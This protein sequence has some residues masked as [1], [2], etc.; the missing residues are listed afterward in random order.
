MVINFKVAGKHHILTFTGI[1]KLASTFC[2]KCIFQVFR[3]FKTSCELYLYRT[4]GNFTKSLSRFWKIQNIENHL[5]VSYI[6]SQKAYCGHGACILIL[7][8]VWTMQLNPSTSQL[9]VSCRRNKRSEFNLM[10]HSAPQLPI[11]NNFA[12]M[13]LQI[14]TSSPIL[15]PLENFSCS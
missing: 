6:G 15:L 10:F 13:L 5:M 14:L 8:L 9:K 7:I 11:T 3:K 4:F 2:K 12:M 1:G